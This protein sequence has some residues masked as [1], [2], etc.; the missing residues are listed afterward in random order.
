MKRVSPYELSNH[1][2][3]VLTVITDRKIPVD[4]NNDFITDY[5]L[6]D[7]IS[8]T[9]YYAFGSPMPGRQF[10]AGNYRYGFNN[11]E[12][13]NEIAGIGNH[14]DFK[15]RGY[16]PRLGRFWS[17]D[18]LFKDFP[19][20][21]NYA[22]A[23]NRV[24]DG[25]DLEGKEFYSV[26]IKENA[27]G[28]RTKLFVTDY[29]QTEKGFGPRG[30]VGVTYVIHKHDA[31]GNFTGFDQFNVKN[32][33]GVYQ[34]K[35]NPRKFWEK[36]N[37]KGEY[38]YDYSLR[39]IDE[40]DRT[41]RTHD[42]NYDKKG[43]EGL[44]GVANP[45]SNS[46][47]NEYTGSALKTIGKYILGMDDNVTEKPVTGKAASAAFKGILFFN[48]AGKAGKDVYRTVENVGKAIGISPDAK[49]EENKK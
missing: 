8:S 38:P 30:D 27:D 28:S 18:P 32:S 1:L 16:D 40:Q 24:I 34:G 26:H 31:K 41:A 36:P 9:D 3:N 19:W 17:V 12:K 46:A 47:D 10:N 13:D 20:N 23:E 5:Y 37:E 35:D 33:Y 2:G 45:E 48:T 4:A 39:P 22:F 15:F 6:P 7:V 29:T 42:R 25:I 14:I 11:M 49:T 44:L 43:L 21:S